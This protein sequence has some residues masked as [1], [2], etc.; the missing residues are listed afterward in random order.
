[1]KQ[2]QF[3]IRLDADIHKKLKMYAVDKEISIQKII[4]DLLMKHVIKDEG[5]E[6]A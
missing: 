3:V 1:M 4:V 2:T 6:N 5:K